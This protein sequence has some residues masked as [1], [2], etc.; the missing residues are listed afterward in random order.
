MAYTFFYQTDIGTIGISENG[1]G[2]TAV[3]FGDTVRN[4]EDQV[5][6]TP[7]IKEAH[8]QLDAYF[9]GTRKTFDL[10]FDLQG[11]EFQQ[12]VWNALMQIPYGRTWTYGE[13][14][15]SI[16]QPTAARAV[17]MA[18]NR[19][20]ICVMVP[21]HRVIGSDGKLVG[22]AGGLSIKEYLLQLEERNKNVARQI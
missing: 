8:K 21:C 5:M 9:S 7:I 1:Q 3:Y 15:A 20:P 6:E 14:A 16:G 19:N 4:S 12:K 10:P 18:N 13:V 11:T 17:G 2:I 22:Y